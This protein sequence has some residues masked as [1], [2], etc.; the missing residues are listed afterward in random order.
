MIR[1][2]F[3][4]PDV[5]QRGNRISS[6][7]SNQGGAVE[8][9]SAPEPALADHNDILALPMVSQGSSKSGEII[10]AAGYGDD[11]ENAIDQSGDTRDR[12]RRGI[13]R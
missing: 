11:G 6:A 2:V 12:T 1:Q 13:G 10:R 3:R 5:C 8:V 7:V 4:N 9:R